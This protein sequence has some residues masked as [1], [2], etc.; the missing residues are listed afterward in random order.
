M[1]HYNIGLQPYKQRH[2]T[3][4][5]TFATC[6]TWTNLVLGLEQVKQTVVVVDA[7]M[8]THWKVVPGRQEWVSVIE[9]ISADKRVLPPLVIFKATTIDSSWSTN[10]HVYDWRF[11]ASTKG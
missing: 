11:L 2:K 7:T 9:C 3:K 10:L 4:T 6:T 5:T 8:R 1:K